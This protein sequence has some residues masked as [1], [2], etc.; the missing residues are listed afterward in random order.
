MTLWL[1]AGALAMS[2][3][4]AGIYIS[5]AIHDHRIAQLSATQYMAMHQMRD[6]SFKRVMPFIGLGRSSW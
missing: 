5:T 3:L 1:V 2:G 6:A 4:I